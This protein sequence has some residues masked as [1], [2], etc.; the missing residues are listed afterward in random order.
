MALKLNG[1]DSRLRRADFRIFSDI[2][3]IRAAAADAAIDRLVARL[4]KAVD[5][6]AL[7]LLTDYGTNGESMAKQMLDIVR[8]RLSSFA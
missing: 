3:G 7:P 5:T 6:V 4:A 8:A 2:A 1:K